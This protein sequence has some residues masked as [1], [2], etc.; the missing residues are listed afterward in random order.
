VIAPLA[1][2]YLARALPDPETAPLQ[3]RLT[4]E[5]QMWQKPKARPR[6]FTATQHIAV[7]RVAFSWRARFGFGPFALAVADGYSHGHG[8]LAVR[9]LGRTLQHE[10]GVETSVGEAMRYLAELPWA[11]AAMAANGALAWRTC[12]ACTAEVAAP[13]EPGAP[14]V[15]FEFDGVGDIIRASS[16][17]RPLRQDG[18][19]VPTPW[20]GDF[21]DYRELGGMRMPTSAEVGWDLPGGRFVYWRARVT[22]ALALETPFVPGS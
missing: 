15:T 7:D 22:S 11:P 2:G 17:A 16:E 5:G 3:V 1:A 6:R 12:D 20:S 9:M 19:W 18:V 13:A 21:S 14:A 4:Q 10:E 8:T